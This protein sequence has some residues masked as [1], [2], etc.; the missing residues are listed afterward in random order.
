MGGVDMDEGTPNNSHVHD[1]AAPTE[2]TGNL[3]DDILNGAY[4]G[5]RD[6]GG[7][8]DSNAAADNL[9]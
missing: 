2:A 8:M 4:E 7:L 5:S 9:L 3:V 6:A 1:S